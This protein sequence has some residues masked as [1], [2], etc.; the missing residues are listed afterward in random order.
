[1]NEGPKQSWLTIR[2]RTL[3]LL[4]LGSGCILGLIGRES[5]QA[6][7]REEAARELARAASKIEIEYCNF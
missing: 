4:T 3:L 5:R 1:M 6:G 2:L 7:R